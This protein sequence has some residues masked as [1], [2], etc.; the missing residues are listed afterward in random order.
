M[1]GAAALVWTLAIAAIFTICT[2]SSIEKAERSEA[3]KAG[4]AEYIVEMVGN[5][6][7]PRFR[8]KTREMKSVPDEV[9]VKSRIVVDEVHAEPVILFSA[10]S[11][12]ERI[13]EPNQ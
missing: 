1:W 4:V 10:A 11:K 5:E 6:P 9:A 8:F 13:P 7:T 3:I 2:R 12:V